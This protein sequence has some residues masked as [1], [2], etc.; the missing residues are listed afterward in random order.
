MAWTVDASAVALVPATKRKQSR[1]VQ[2]GEMNEDAVRTFPRNP[3]ETWYSG[4]EYRKFKKMWKMN[5]TRIEETK[6]LGFCFELLGLQ[7]P[8]VGTHETFSKGAWMSRLK[9]REVVFQHQDE[10]RS[11]GMYDADEASRLSMSCSQLDQTKALKAAAYNAEEAI[12]YRKYITRL[13]SPTSVSNFPPLDFS[14]IS[15]PFQCANSLSCVNWDFDGV[16]GGEILNYQK[17]FENLY[18]EALDTGSVSSE[19]A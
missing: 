5:Q 10:C 17:K 9:L 18:A 2:F 6:E 1:K 16:D 11:R 19:Y 4:E 15:D 7:D 12:E 3:K 8:P 14:S 13:P